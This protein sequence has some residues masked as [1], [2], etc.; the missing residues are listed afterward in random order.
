MYYGLSSLAILIVLYFLY[1]KLFHKKK[2]KA[3]E[4]VFTALLSALT[5]IGNLLSFSVLPLQMGTAMVVISGVSFGAEAGFLVGSLSRLI[6]NIFQGQGPWTPWQMAAWGLIGALSGMMFDKK[7]G[8]EKTE[9]T[10]KVLLGLLLCFVVAQVCAYL[11][12]VLFPIK[13]EESFFAFRIYVFGLIGF[14]AGIFF[15]RNKFPTNE[16]V[17]SVFTFLVVLILYGGI[18]NLCAYV[19]G[20]SFGRQEGFDF[21]ALRILY[22]S[23]LPYDLW[24]AIRAS[25]AVFLLGPVFVTKFERVKIKYGFYRAKR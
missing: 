5:V 3:R 16:I 9:G 10:L 25:I 17:M 19:T 1:K 21:Q 7:D 15:I 24:H 4:I 13:G 6:C 11:S 23:G 20:A 18:M 8:K 14:V 2:K 12:Y 22:V